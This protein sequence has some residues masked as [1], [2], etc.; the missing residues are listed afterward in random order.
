MDHEGRGREA[1]GGKD[2]EEEKDVRGMVQIEKEKTL[3]TFYYGQR[4]AG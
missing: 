3:L 2:V 4:E 1:C